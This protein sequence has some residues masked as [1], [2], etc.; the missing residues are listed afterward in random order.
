MD[1]PKEEQLDDFLRMRINKEQFDKYREK[2]KTLTNG[3]Y[4]TF[5]RELIRAFNEGRVTI[6][7]ETNQK[8]MFGE[9][10]NVN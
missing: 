1:N 10:Y 6:T 7:L 8:L 5:T 4:P 2:V 3:D 9:T